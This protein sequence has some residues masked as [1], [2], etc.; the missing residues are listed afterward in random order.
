MAR[1]P[2]VSVKEL[3]PRFHALEGSTRGKIANLIRDA[4][5]DA[6]TPQLSSELV[7]TAAI[8]EEINRTKSRHASNVYDTLRLMAAAGEIIRKQVDER[9]WSY[10]LASNAPPVTEFQS[11]T[12]RSSLSELLRAHM[13]NEAEPRSSQYYDHLLRT[14]DGTATKMGIL[15]TVLDRMVESGEVV[16]TDRPPR[17][18]VDIRVPVRGY[19]LAE[20]WQGKPQAA[21]MHKGKKKKALVAATPRRVGAVPRLNGVDID[22]AVRSAIARHG[23]MVTVRLDNQRAQT[24]TGREARWVWQ[25]LTSLFDPQSGD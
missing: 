18:S 6:K 3:A 13:K 10:I 7:K 19:V 2:Q 22:G 15:R 11:G 23:A 24:F 17:Q 20:F 25:Q 14:K 21:R 9:H 16:I 5:K 1:P 4:L 12:Q 8:A